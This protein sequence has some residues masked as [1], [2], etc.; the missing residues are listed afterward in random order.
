MLKK[1]TTAPL[2]HDCLSRSSAIPSDV[3][4]LAARE[5][6]LIKIVKGNLKCTVLFVIMVKHKDNH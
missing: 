2:I 1:E 5:D 4:C 6:N 3:H